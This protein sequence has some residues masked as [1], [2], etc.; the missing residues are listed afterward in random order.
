MADA[1]VVG[2]GPNGLAAAVELARSGLSVT[3]I[4]ASLVE[5]IGVP[6]VCWSRQAEPTHSSLP[7]LN[8]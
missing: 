2:S 1:V 6:S 4:A 5:V 3:V 7:S 8:T